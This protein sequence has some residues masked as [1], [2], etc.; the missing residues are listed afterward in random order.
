MS[1]V[2]TSGDCERVGEAVAR[3]PEAL[4]GRPCVAADARW[5]VDGRGLLLACPVRDKL[6]GPH[7]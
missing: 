2:W 4:V 5:A 6:K 3:L 1:R 7:L